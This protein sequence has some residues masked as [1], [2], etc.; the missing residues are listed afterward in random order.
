MNQRKGMTMMDISPKKITIDDF[1]KIDDGFYPIK[2]KITATGIWV[3][4]K[5]NTIPA[6][7]YVIP[8]SSIR[9]TSPLDKVVPITI[10]KDF[11]EKNCLV[12][13]AQTKRYE[14]SYRQDTPE[15]YYLYTIKYIPSSQLLTIEKTQFPLKSFN[16]E[17]VVKKCIYI[18]EWQQSLRLLDINTSVRV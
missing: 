8:S 9:F 11:L 18:H 7:E 4:S 2:A 17:K 3:T 10:D 14:Y 16:V 13:N 12:F 15:G 1:V 6:I 5:G